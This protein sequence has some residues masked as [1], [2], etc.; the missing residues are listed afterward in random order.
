MDF[1]IKNTALLSASI[2]AGVGLLTLITNLLLTL[3]RSKYEET[4][5]YHKTV[6]DKLEKVYNPLIKK[7]R[8]KEL[9]RYLIDSE[10]E[11]IIEKYGYLLSSSLFEDFMILLEIEQYHRSSENIFDIRK[12]VINKLSIVSTLENSRNI[13]LTNE[14]INLRQKIIR[15]LDQEFR[16]LK[17]YNESSFKK[18]KNK[19]S[20]TLIQDIKEK[21]II[22]FIFLSVPTWLRAAIFFYLEWIQRNYKISGNPYK[23]GIYFIYIIIVMLTS[24][25]GLSW[26]IL[27]VLEKIN[28]KLGR[29]TNKYTSLDYVPETGFYFCRITKE[30]LLK[31]KYTQFG[32]PQLL[33]FTQR[34]RFLFHSNFCWEKS[35]GETK[36]PDTEIIQENFN[37]M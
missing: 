3:S 17:S 1:F 2:A 31:E 37:P 24:I 18:Y 12:E 28:N 20:R 36:T 9:Q 16:E 27:K 13:D 5:N 25:F 8:S 19:M 35:K 23:D 4:N 21:S 30:N 32:Y 10:T 15:D 22:T 33:T 34:V 6:T 7:T 11:T 29:I 26:I 14:Q